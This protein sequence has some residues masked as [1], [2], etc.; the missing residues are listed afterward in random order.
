[1]KTIKS[2]L[3]KYFA[4]LFLVL[5]F[6]AATW[7]LYRP[8]FF[9]IHDWTQGA[10][11]AEMGR[12][13]NEGQFPVRWSANFG[14]GFGMPLFNFYAPLPYYLGGLLYNLGL[15]LVVCLKILYLLP[16]FLAML[17]AFKLGK[18]I[19]GTWAG[20]ILAAAYTLAPYR[21][22]NL[23]V[24]GAVSEAWAMAFMPWV[25][26]AIF[27]LLK[28]FKKKINSKPKYLILVLSLVGIFLSHNLTAMI[29]IPLSGLLAFILFLEEENWSLKNTLKDIVPVFLIYLL[30]AALSAFYLLPAVMEKNDTIIDIIFS[31]YFHYSNHFLYIRQFLKPNWQYGGSG[32][33]PEDGISFF[34]GWG[35]ILGLVFLVLAVGIFL[36]KN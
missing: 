19:S 31:G 11:I 29:F 18:K 30:S 10:R 8:G 13:L 16:T 36:L 28:N 20:I 15:N 22:V 23:F 14:Y 27:A 33:G 32:W 7:S 12:A 1:M 21:A 5:I 2:L 17:G 9:H 25:L 35:Q 6:I 3:S 4:F 26:N 24:R 34:F